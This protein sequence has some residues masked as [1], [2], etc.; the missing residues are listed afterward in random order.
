MEKF[1]DKDFL[2]ETETVK[3][4]LPYNCID[5]LVGSGLYSND[6]DFLET[7]FQE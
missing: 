1:P 4:T 6:I 5:N 2:P 3:N 7:L